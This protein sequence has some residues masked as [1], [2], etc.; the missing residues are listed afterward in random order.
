M[1][2]GSALVYRMLCLDLRAI[3]RA[4][5]MYYLIYALRLFRDINSL[6]KES[7]H[8]NIRVLDL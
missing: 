2:R 4:C 7:L 8:K 1:K 3:Y 5:A 6:A